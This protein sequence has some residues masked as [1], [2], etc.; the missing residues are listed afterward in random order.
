MARKQQ[1]AQPRLIR[2]GKRKGG[3]TSIERIK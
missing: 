2:R 1:T 3:M